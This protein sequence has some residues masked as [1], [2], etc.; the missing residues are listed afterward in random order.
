MSIVERERVGAPVVT[1][2]D[3][4]E[5]A[6]DLLDSGEWG[7]CQGVA[8]DGDSVCMLGAIAIAAGATLVEQQ[9]QLD[10]DTPLYIRSREWLPPGQRATFND[11]PG[12]ARAEVV[13][14]LREA[15]ARAREAA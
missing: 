2:A 13:A 14:K 15:A 7:W 3:V 6:A 9:R 4:L 11:E 12:R 10:V 5:R 8:R 1:E